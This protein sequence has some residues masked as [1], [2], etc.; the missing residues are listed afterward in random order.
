MM[1]DNDDDADDD[2]DEFHNGDD[3]DDD[4]DGVSDSFHVSESES[5]VRHTVKSMC[6]ATESIAVACHGMVESIVKKPNMF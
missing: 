3:D 1:N 5:T 4:G 6:I 2:D